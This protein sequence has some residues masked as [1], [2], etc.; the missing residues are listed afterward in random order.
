MEYVHTAFGCRNA[1]R[2]DAPLAALRE[3]ATRYMERCNPHLGVV[4]CP[5]Y[6]GALC[7]RHRCTLASPEELEAAG[8][9]AHR[10]F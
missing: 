9:P 10:G 5:Y 3:Q 2:K 8:E 7:T 1:L 6:T 4:K